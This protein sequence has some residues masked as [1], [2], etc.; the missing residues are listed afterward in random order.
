VLQ[1]LSRKQQRRLDC[2]SPRD[3]RNGIDAVHECQD[4]LTIAGR[5]VKA[6]GA[7]VRTKFGSRSSFSHVVTPLAALGNPGG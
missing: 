3:G 5:Y 7:Q 2:H 1:K 6:E 4:D